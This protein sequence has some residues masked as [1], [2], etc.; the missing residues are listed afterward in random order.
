M[1]Y[2]IQKRKRRVD[3]KLLETKSYYLRYRVGRMPGDKWI[4]LDTTDKAVATKKA[5]DFIKDLERELA[6]L[7]VPK[8][9]IE[10]AAAPL[11]SLIEEYRKEL[12]T[13]GRDTKYVD[14]TAKRLVAI[15]AECGWK[16]VR[17][18][19]A[20]SF[21]V[22]R[23][24]SHLKS[25][26]KNDCLSDVRSFLQ[27]LVEFGRCA[28]NP[29]IKVPRIKV[30]DDEEEK[31]RAFSWEEVERLFKRSG[32]RT[33][34]YQTKLFCGLRRGELAEL[35]WGD[36]FVDRGGETFL[37]LR[38]STTKNGKTT[39]QPVPDWLAQLLQKHRPA[40]I[41]LSDP[42]FPIIPRMP[43]FLKDLDA[44]GI[45][46]VDER[47]HVSKFH[48]LRHT[49]G[50]WL[51][52]TGADPRV[53]MKLM[54]HSSLE[55]TVK[56]YTDE[57]GLASNDAVKRLPSFGPASDALIQIRT[58]ISGTDGQIVSNAGES[59]GIPVKPKTTG[60]KRL[61]RALSWCGEV[62]QMVRAAGFEPA[63]P[64]V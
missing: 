37:K 63:T 8:K 42:I 38:A 6:G 34:I 43:R 13:R 35:K 51:W 57:A 9:E 23:R 52:A 10:T 2:S 55:L 59:A 60:N 36:V 5:S 22:W 32:P 45:P 19:T 47:G 3:G 11:A 4:T 26:T 27:W 7:A 17:D 16:T 49:L 25:K 30:K 41:K 28:A 24:S 48:S 29:L 53:I 61:S 1:I 54:R 14:S 56:R 15:A 33:I 31:R 39:P 44:A 21:M 40:S 62:G 46:R 58:Q 50:T 18:V 20:D 64:S 12:E